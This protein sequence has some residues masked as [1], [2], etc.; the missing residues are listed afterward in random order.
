MQTKA[1]RRRTGYS[2]LIGI[3]L[4]TIPCYLI[5]FAALFILQR[6][7]Q[8]VIGAATSTPQ[9]TLT[10]APTPTLG[11]LPTQFV[12]PTVA[13]TQPVVATTPPASPTA[14]A[15]LFPTLAPATPTPT[16][17]PIV[18]V[19]VIPPETPAIQPTPDLALSPTPIP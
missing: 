17:V 11:E 15:T 18:T 14:T 12:P 4:L 10:N 16:A 2:V 8:T 5:G 19:I 9:P 13:P 6:P 1:A 3:I 7:G